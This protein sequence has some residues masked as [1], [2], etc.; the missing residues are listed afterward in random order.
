MLATA[1]A[2]TNSGSNLGPEPSP[3]RIVNVGVYIDRDGS[4]TITSLDTVYAKARV[5]LLIRGSVDTFKA[6]FSNA[7]GLAK[8]SDVPLGQ[9]TVAIDPKSIGDSIQVQAVDS[10]DIRV[11]AADSAIGVVAR[12]G[13][14]EVSIRQVRSLPSGRRVFVRGIVLAG[15]QSFRDTTSHLSD[16]TGALRLTRVALRGGL[17]GNNPGDSVSVLGIIS[18]R[19]GQ[20]TLDLASISRFATR[21]APIALP[22]GTGPAASASN[23]VLDAALVQITGAIISDTLTVAPD[24]RVTVSDGTGTLDIIMD[25][26]LPPVSR[27]VFAPGRSMSAKGV[28]VPTGLGGWVLKPRELSDVNLN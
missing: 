28:L 17:N 2:C 7:N 13:Y 8:F 25:G 18:S 26:N 22:I 23:G 12:L 9:Y 21:P 16:S 15:V 10:A 27:S 1:G 20:P 14:P 5:A 19:A 3:T 24:F 4:R 11:T 6:V